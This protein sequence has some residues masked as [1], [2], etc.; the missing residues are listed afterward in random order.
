[1]RPPRPQLDAGLL[2]R[3]R[4]PVART[5]RIGA[6]DIVVDHHQVDRLP[7]GE[8]L[9][10]DESLSNESV[11]EERAGIARRTHPPDHACRPGQQ[12][13]V[14]RQRLLHARTAE[15]TLGQGARQCLMRQA[16]MTRIE[17][18]VHT[19]GDRLHV[20]RTLAAANERSVHDHRV[21]DDDTGKPQ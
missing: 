17:E 11:G 14:A 5:G 8:A 12:R 4:R 21:G 2:E 15:R 16:G 19:R 3:R 9:P 13:L 7:Q 10:P 18:E 6:P 20:R 1:M